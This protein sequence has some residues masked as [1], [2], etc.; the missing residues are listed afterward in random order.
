MPTRRPL[1]LA[2][3]S[4]AHFPFDISGE[5]FQPD[6]R[7]EA[8]SQ[9]ARRCL[10]SATSPPC[11]GR[12][13]IKAFVTKYPNKNFL[14]AWCRISAPAC[15]STGTFQR[16]EQPLQEGREVPAAS[17][18]PGYSQGL[19]AEG[20]DR[21]RSSGQP[22]HDLRLAQDETPSE[23]Y[24]R[25]GPG[26]S[27][28]GRHSQGRGIYITDFYSFTEN[29]IQQFVQEVERSTGPGLPDSTGLRK[30]TSPPENV[31]NRPPAWGWSALPCSSYKPLGCN[32]IVALGGNA[33]A[34][35]TSV[36]SGTFF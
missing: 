23:C 9:T 16:P 14:P 34:F 1:H 4:S 19:T 2:S 15:P 5:D 26:T 18:Q 27:A 32:K 11:T 20:V 24:P 25:P 22:C 12:H 17:L 21:P 29:D 35:F 28:A 6:V 36:R 10:S 31:S 30:R 7:G 13:S 8:G 3:F 33:L